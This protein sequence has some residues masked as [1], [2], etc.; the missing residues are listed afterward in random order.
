MPFQLTVSQYST[1]F[2][3]HSFDFNQNDTLSKKNNFPDRC[4]SYSRQHD[5]NNS[6]H[7]EVRHHLQQLQ[8]RYR[9]RR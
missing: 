2:D 9:L 5:Q 1:Q 3:Q 8:L 7:W 4:I 6:I